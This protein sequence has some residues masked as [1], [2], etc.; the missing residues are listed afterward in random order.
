MKLIEVEWWDAYELTDWSANEDL[1]E[2]ISRYPEGLL[3]KSVGYVLR[4]NENLIFIGQTYQPDEPI[5]ERDVSN[6][7]FIPK[8]SIKNVTVLKDEN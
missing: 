5:T 7:I 8:I 3:T 6:M 2:W 1:D 4:E